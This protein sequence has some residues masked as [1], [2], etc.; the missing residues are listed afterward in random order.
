MIERDYL[1]IGAGTAGVSVCEGIRLHDKR[2]K[3]TL[4]GNESSSLPTHG[5]PLSRSGSSARRNFDRRDSTFHH[6]AEL[7][8]GAED[9]P[10]AQH[11][12]HPAQSG[13]P[14]RRV[15]SNGQTIEFKKACLATGSRP[16]RPQVAGTNLGN[17][18][19]LRTIG[20]ARA[21]KEM[22]ALEGEHR[23]SSAAATS[24]VE[25]AAALRQRPKC[26][27][28]LMTRDSDAL[29]PVPRRRDSAAWLTG[30]VPPRTESHCTSRRS[31]NGFEGKTV[32]R[33]IQTKNGNRFPAS[34]ALVARRLARL[35]LE[36]VRN[37]PLSSAKGTPVNEFLETDEKG[38]LRRR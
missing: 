12:R 2:G 32:L 11:R 26:K 13:P 9:R 5:S 19:Y 35:N 1:V 36:L 22:V 10:P 23:R 6:P 18:I 27:V 34:L 7:V 14:P 17:I 37:T 4:V 8:R 30:R 3:L 24:R 20:D 33:N 16:F 15:L 29:E 38:I 28:S 25:A 21:L 31:L